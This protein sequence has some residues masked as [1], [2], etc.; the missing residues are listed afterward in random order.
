MQMV[1]LT[2]SYMMWLCILLVSLWGGIV[3]ELM[4]RNRLK[5]PRWASLGRQIVVS[6]FAGMLGALLG[7]ELGFSDY[8]KVLMAGFFSLT[9]IQSAKKMF[10]LIMFRKTGIK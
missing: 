2:E 9:D 8:M 10:D 6:V 7:F 4:K 3:R 5:K 1:I